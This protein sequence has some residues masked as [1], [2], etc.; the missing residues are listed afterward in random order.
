DQQPGADIPRDAPAAAAD[1]NASGHR[2]PGSATGTGTG[3]DAPAQ[4]DAR[5][6]A[7]QRAGIGSGQHAAAAAEVIGASAIHDSTLATIARDVLT[8]ADVVELVDTLA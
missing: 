1:E 7:W 5:E 4:L 8:I 6:R 3:C 2:R